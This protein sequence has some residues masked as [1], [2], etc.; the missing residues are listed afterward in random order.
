MKK[1]KGYTLLFAV[2]VS[3]LL[4]SIAA[5]IL[6]VSR[7]EA[8]LS[9]SA[10]DSVYAYYA[11]ES[12]FECVL[13][14]LG[15]LAGTNSW[16]TPQTINCG[17]RPITFTTIPGTNAGTSSF[18]LP[19][20]GTSGS[21]QSGLSSCA[22]TTISEVSTISHGSTTVDVSVSSHGYNIGWNGTDCG[23]TG[24]RKVER[25]LLYTTTRTF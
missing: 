10:R 22:A 21:T 16:P 3:V 13:E 7:K 20:G 24:P 15:T 4:L 25:A 5:F 19:V 9:S 17:G 12:G 1:N 2:I 23:L 18:S 11:A 14:N 8:I 6:S